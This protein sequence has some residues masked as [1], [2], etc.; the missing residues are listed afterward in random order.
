MLKGRWAPFLR[1]PPGFS[2]RGLGAARSPGTETAAFLAFSPLHGVF[3]NRRDARLRKRTLLSLYLPQQ[4][5]WRCFVRK[6][7]E[8]REEEEKIYIYI[9]KKKIEPPVLY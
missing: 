8:M 7:P 2:S 5:A 3:L 6:I 9:Y 4:S 1:T